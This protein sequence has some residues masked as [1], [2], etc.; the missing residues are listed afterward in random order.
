MRVIKSFNIDT[1]ELNSN[2]EKR[3][4]HIFGD[5]GAVFTLEVKNSDGQYYNFST[6]TFAS[7]KK[8]LTKK[9]LGDS[10]KGDITFPAATNKT[11]DLYLWAEN[12]YKTKHASYKEVRF[13]DGS[14]DINSSTG[15]NSDLLQ[16]KLYQYQ[17]S[18]VTLTA[19]SPSS[20]T[21]WGS[22]SV[23]NDTI[24]GQRG[25]KTYN[26][27]FTITVLAAS[28]RSI[29]INRQPEINDFYYTENRNIGDPVDIPGEDIYPTA[30]DAF[31][32]DDINGAITSGSV[33]RMDNTDLSAAIKVGDKITTTVMTDTVNGARDASGVAVTMD[34]AVATKM[35][36]GDRVTGNAAL[37]STIITVASLDSTNVF[38][39]SSAVA[40]ADGVT[41]SFSS[42]INRSVTTVTVVETSG[43]ATDFT[44][45]Q[46]IQ[47]RDNAPLTFWPRKNYRWAIKSNSSLHSLQENM[48]ATGTN[49]SASSSL[50]PYS[51]Y[52]E[53]TIDEA[54]TASDSEVDRLEEVYDDRALAEDVAEEHAEEQDVVET[55]ALSRIIELPAIDTLNF[56]PTITDGVVSKQLGNII[57]NNQQVLELT[58]DTIAFWAYGPSFINTFTGGTSIELSN[59]KVELTDVATTVNDSDA[60]GSDALSTFTLA[61]AAGII[62]DVSFMSGVNVTASGGRPRVTNISTNT[63]TVTPGDHILQNGQALTFKGSSRTAT[64]TGNIKISNLK[65]NAITLGFDLESFLSAV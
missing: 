61:S 19:S 14:I 22:V 13:N 39:L 37:D 41:L 23:T 53:Y 35:A 26:K 8:K 55:S 56:Q 7:A 21:A 1:G 57:F 64:I 31:T 49:V 47:F 3:S 59:L 15:S 43:T 51:S 27:D 34:S 6:R 20:L 25:Q 2:K 36:V 30:R 65:A 18:V 48:L 11:Y 12:R 60:N 17:D 24:T 4:F 28:S 54:V 40:I 62:D 29:S 9:I 33:V 5:N 46:A 10:F 38:S 16:K 63:I 52:L 45:S 50:A 44:M 58:D 42:K 32:G